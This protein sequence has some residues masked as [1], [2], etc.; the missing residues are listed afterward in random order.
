MFRIRV[1]ID[2]DRLRARG[3]LVRSGLPGVGYVKFDPAVDWPAKLQ[4]PVPK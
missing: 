3:A 2:P 1:K 4:G